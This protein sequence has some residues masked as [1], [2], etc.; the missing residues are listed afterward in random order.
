MAKSRKNFRAN[1]RS[2]DRKTV[3]VTFAFNDEYD[4]WFAPLGYE[5]QVVTDIAEGD[6]LDE[7]YEDVEKIIH[8]NRSYKGSEISYSIDRT[9][10]STEKQN[11]INIFFSLR[12]L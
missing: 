9:K 10:T 6:T 12:N 1:V 11:E 4:Y 7:L 8:A 2:L 5:G 3:V